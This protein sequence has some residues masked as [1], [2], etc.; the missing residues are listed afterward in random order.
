[1]CSLVFELKLTFRELVTM[2]AEQGIGTAH[3]TILRWVQRFARSVGGS[4]RMA[5][6]YIRVKGE[7]VYLD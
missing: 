4:W 2:M 7:W 6:T 1:M 3:A 5:E